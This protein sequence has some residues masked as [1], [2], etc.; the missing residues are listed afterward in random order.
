M[1]FRWIAHSLATA[2]FAFAAPGAEAQTYS[3][4]TLVSSNLTRPDQNTPWYAFGPP[5]LDGTEVIFMTKNAQVF[6]TLDGIWAYD[7]VHATPRK[8]AGLSTPA[9][10]GTGNFTGFGL[11]YA[12]DNP[13]PSAGGGW[14]VFYGTDSAGVHGLYSADESTGEIYKIVT[15]ATRAPDGD[16]FTY[17]AHARTNGKTLVFYGETKATRGI[18][19][20][21]VKGHGLKTV[22]DGSTAEN[23]RGYGGGKNYYGLYTAPI[24]GPSEIAFYATGIGDPSQY[25]NEV[26]QTTGKGAVSGVA[27]NLTPLKGDPAGLGHTQITGYSAALNAN[28]Y[29]FGAFD[30]AY[31]GIFQST[32]SLGATAPFV[33]STKM[34]VPGG[35]DKFSSFG[36]FSFD[37]TGVAFVGDDTAFGQ[38]VYIRAFGKGVFQIASG[39]TYYN[40]TIGDLSLSNGQ[41]AF[42]DGS[43]YGNAIYLATPK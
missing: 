13:L 33:A 28:G 23:A 31:S 41:L 8:L 38:S 32:A 40:P 42:F 18:F 19:E 1:H 7:T 14:T 43:I 36:A 4:K 39:K 12:S 27:D 9:P 17:F 35:K 30:G 15:T 2:A 6:A 11:F 26:F 37:R 3:V 21:N 10:G 20:T 25:P 5:V 16:A 24:L 34:T 22:I 29:A